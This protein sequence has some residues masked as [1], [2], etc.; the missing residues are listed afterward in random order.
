[1]AAGRSRLEAVQARLI[2]VS[3]PDGYRQIFNSVLTAD[4][5]YP[6]SCCLRRKLD[7]YAG[8]RV[9]TVSL[10]ACCTVRR[11]QPAKRSRG[12]SRP[13]FHISRPMLPASTAP[14]PQFAT[15]YD[16]PSHRVRW[17][18]SYGI[19]EFREIEIFF[20][21]WLDMFCRFAGLV[22]R[23]T[24]NKHAKNYRHY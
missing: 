18:L 7:R 16:R 20:V 2:S 11:A 12:S 3:V 4:T 24:Q 9:H 22:C 6:L 14:H 21:R 19:S 23:S 8:G 17:N 5:A 10:Y 15:T 13:A 1:M